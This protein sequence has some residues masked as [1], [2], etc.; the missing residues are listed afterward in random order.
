MTSFYRFNSLLIFQ[1]KGRYYVVTK[2]FKAFITGKGNED[3]YIGDYDDKIAE[4][5]I[6]LCE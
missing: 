2:N 4:F 3:I 6:G 1:Y 5:I